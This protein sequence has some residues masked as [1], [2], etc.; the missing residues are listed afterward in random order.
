M[1]RLHV[2]VALALIL[3]TSALYAQTSTPARAASA[4]AMRDCE[5]ARHDHGAEK[6]TPSPKSVRCAAD[7]M[8]GK[9]VNK[10]HDHNKV[11]K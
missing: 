11:H 2:P 6:G 4:A 3:A 7:D 5:K 9:K 10:A 1:K 8:K